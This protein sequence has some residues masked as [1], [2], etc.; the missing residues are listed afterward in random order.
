M[1]FPFTEEIVLNSCIPA[2][3]DFCIWMIRI[4]SPALNA[5]ELLTLMLELPA[6]ALTVK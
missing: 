4:S 2:P 6:T 3:E 1:L 5:E